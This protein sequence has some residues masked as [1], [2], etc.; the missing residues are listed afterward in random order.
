MGT[1]KPAGSSRV[2]G[3]ADGDISSFGYLRARMMRR[4]LACSNPCPLRLARAAG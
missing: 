1:E 2:G 4:A 3:S